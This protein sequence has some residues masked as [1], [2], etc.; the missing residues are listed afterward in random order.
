MI[1]IVFACKSNSCRSQMAEGWAHQWIIDEVERHK[2]AIEDCH[3]ID[4]KKDV[5]DSYNN[6]LTHRVKDYVSSLENIAVTS[7]ALDSSAVFDAPSSMCASTL[8]SKCQRKQVKSKAVEAMAKDGVDI[9]LFRP[10]TIDESIPFLENIAKPKSTEEMVIEGNGK[11]PI[12]SVDK[13]IVLCS[14][15]EEMKYELTRRSISVEEWSIDAPTAAS[16]AGEG[17]KAYQRVSLEIKEKVNILM[18]SLKLSL[19]S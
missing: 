5:I 6:H 9:S 12:K 15:G 10:K 1:T 19:M 8:A 18:R 17:D 7:V 16:K 11:S 2:T 3:Y 13:L 14:C 4:E